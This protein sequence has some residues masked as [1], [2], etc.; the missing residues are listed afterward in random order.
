MSKLD[1]SLR[2]GKLGSETP[3]TG[4]GNNNGG[5]N[6]G[7][8][9]KPPAETNPDFSDAKLPVSSGAKAKDVN[10]TDLNK[11]VAKLSD[12]SVNGIKNNGYEVDMADADTIGFSEDNLSITFIRSNGKA[13]LRYSSNVDSNLVISLIKDVT[14]I[15]VDKSK[16]YPSYESVINANLTISANGNGNYMVYY[17]K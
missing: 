11:N 2:L 14:G 12:K 5:N 17:S 9:T 7:G 15:T 13:N 8:N 6:N 3:S 4:G 1:S 10:V 16:L